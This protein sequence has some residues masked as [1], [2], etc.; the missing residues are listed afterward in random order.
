[1]IGRPYSN[2]GDY[3]IYA[4]MERLIRD[5]FPN[6]MIEVKLESQGDY[7]IHD[8]NQCDAIVTGGGGAQLS[9][10]YIRNSFVYTHFGEIKIPIH[11]MGTGIYSPNGNSETIYNYKYSEDVKRFLN[12]I[13]EKGGQIASRDWC[14][15]SILRN[16]H[17]RK[18]I[19]TGCPA[20]YDLEMMS[21]KSNLKNLSIDISIKKIAISNQGLT[22][23]PANNSAKLEQIE[24]VIILLK[25]MFPEAEMI[26]TFNDGY[27]TKYS[28][29]FN[30]ALKNWAILQQ[31][32]C[33]D[34]SNDSE[35]FHLLDDVDLHVGYR[36][37][38]HIYCVSKRIRSILIE[39]DIRGFGINDV[40]GLPHIRAYDGNGEEEVF[41]PNV[42]LIK[43]LCMLLEQM[44]SYTRIDY[45]RIFETIINTYKSGMQSWLDNILR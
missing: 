23:N 42:Y 9:E 33:V 36:V 16:N 40:W 15:D 24:Q 12:S 3:L 11:Y 10:T 25:K 26:L 34:L 17:I 19:M 43:E 44:Q 22:K 31:V 8:V 1:M 5:R 4:R 39:E 21:E 18:I 41:K 30:I 7:N 32:K 38:T 35:K 45:N 20:W 13:I 27:I 2:G 29:D 28:K 37:H 14:V 6:A